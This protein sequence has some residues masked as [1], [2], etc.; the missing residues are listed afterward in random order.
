MKIAAAALALALALPAAAAPPAKKFLPEA[1]D[2]IVSFVVAGPGGRLASKSRAQAQSQFNSVLDLKSK[3]PRRSLTI[4]GVP[5][6]NPNNGKARM[7]YKLHASWGDDA[8]ELQSVIEAEIGA[9]VLVYDSEGVTVRIT[10]T[11]AE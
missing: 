2:L 1:S 7:E 4:S 5:V 3:S 10:F 9:D 11:P 6:I 8:V